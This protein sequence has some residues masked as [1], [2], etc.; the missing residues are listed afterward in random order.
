MKN[1]LKPRALVIDRC[2]K[3][4][5]RMGGGDYFEKRI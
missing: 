5:K 1:V 3:N 4:K 2:L